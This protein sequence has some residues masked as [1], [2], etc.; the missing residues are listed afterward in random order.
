MNWEILSQYSDLHKT[1]FDK[2]LWIIYDSLESSSVIFNGTMQAP[3]I[4]AAKY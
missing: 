1:I 3:K 2:E 4:H